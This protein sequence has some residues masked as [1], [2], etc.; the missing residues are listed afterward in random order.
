MKLKTIDT[1]YF[2]RKNKIIN[3]KK[4]IIKQNY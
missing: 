4:S 3:H 1:K 2:N